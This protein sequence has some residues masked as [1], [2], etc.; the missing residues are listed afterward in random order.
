M[1]ITVKEIETAHEEIRGAV[2][3]T[4]LVYSYR[5]SARLGCNLYLKLETQQATG[6]FKD[7]GSLHK[8]LHLDE[9]QQRRGVVAMSAGNHAQGVA[10]HAARL[11]IPAT[12]VMPTFAPFSK[13]E[14]TRSYG[15]KVIKHGDTLDASAVV[16]REL[17]ERDGLAFISPYDDAHIIAGQGSIGLE[18]IEDL[19]ETDAIFVPIGGG[20]VISGTA[21]AAQARKPEVEVYGVEADRYPS[22]IAAIKGEE[23]QFGETTIADGI[24]VKLPGQLT[25]PIVQE[26][27]REIFLCNEDEFETAIA[28]LAE[29]QK[30]VVE[31]A[32]A[33]GLAALTQNKDRFKGRNVVVVICGGNI[34][35]RMFASVMS[36]FLVRS[37]RMMRLRI[38]IVDRPGEMSRLTG[39]ISDC[40]SNILEL[41]HQRLFS[42]VPAKEAEVDA[43]VE[44]SDVTHGETIREQ[45]RAAGYKTQIM[46]TTTSAL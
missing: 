11:G 24:A 20:G 46:E 25:L 31:G 32:G 35:S 21:I 29:Q 27:V 14:R 13:I 22:M 41:H 18:I 3:R 7:R 17:A 5:L 19:P 2:V 28:D 1:S 8:L 15:A 26:R 43:L 10:Y 23:P 45:L 4:P 38:R 9:A 12:V 34:D 39:V 40:G 33:A 36:R 42:D 16:A 44:T 37:S 6:S 30:L